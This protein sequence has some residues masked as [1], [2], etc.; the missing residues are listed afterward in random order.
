VLIV[1]RHAGGTRIRDCRLGGEQDSSWNRIQ[2]A[3]LYI[4]L[5]LLRLHH[6][7]WGL[8]RPNVD[9][10]KTQICRTHDCTGVLCRDQSFALTIFAQQ[11]TTFVDISNT[12]LV[13]FLHHFGR[14]CGH[15]GF[16][17]MFHIPLSASIMRAFLAGPSR[18]ASLVHWMDNKCWRRW[19]CH[20]KTLRASVGTTQFGGA[21]G[22]AIVQIVVGRNVGNNVECASIELGQLR[23][24]QATSQIHGSFHVLQAG[25]NVPHRC[26][27]GSLFSNSH[28]RYP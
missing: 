9:I 7:L 10:P 14:S 25:R 15:S 27:Q 13:F 19:V 21:G 11:Y 17:A 24:S 12:R 5:T 23:S 4:H 2:N 28:A 26:G 1:K 18:S 3:I 20:L 22:I 16:A 8:S 6:F